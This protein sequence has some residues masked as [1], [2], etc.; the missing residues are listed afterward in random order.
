MTPGRLEVPPDDFCH[1]QHLRAPEIVEPV[2]G[3]G[4]HGFGEP[5]GDLVG[6]DGLQV[7]TARYGHD[8]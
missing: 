5:V 2:A 1:R 6:V 7:P 4:C 8:R 3:T